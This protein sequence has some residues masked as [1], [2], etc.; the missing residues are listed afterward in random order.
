MSDTDK[1]LVNFVLDAVDTELGAAYKAK[2]SELKESG[3]TLQQRADSISA[4]FTE[5]G[6]KA[7]ADECLS[8]VKNIDE[9]LRI[10]IVTTY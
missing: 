1:N 6:Y 5:K 2:L 9:V 4:W 3:L 10:T 8:L 7:S